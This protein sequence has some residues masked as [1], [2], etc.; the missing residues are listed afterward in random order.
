[1]AAPENIKPFLKWAGGKYRIIN[2]LRQNIPIKTRFFDVFMGSGA[3][4][5][6]VT[7]PS[8]VAN[9]ANGDVILPWRAMQSDA[10]KFVSDCE[11][12]FTPECDSPSVFYQL[13]QEFNQRT[14]TPDRRAALFVYLNRHSYNGLC[15]YNR[16]GEFNASFAHATPKTCPSDL[17][18]ACV[19]RIGACQFTNFDFREVMGSLMEG[20]VA[21]CDP[22]YWPLSRTAD[23]NRYHSE[24]FLRED[25]NDL[26]QCAVNAAKRGAIVVISNHLTSETAQLYAGASIQP[27]SVLRSISCGAR[28]SAQEAFFTYGGE[29]PLIQF[30]VIVDGSPVCALTVGC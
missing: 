2:Q 16:K 12:L 19:P 15:R 3:V 6:N 10:E 30:P 18:R 8:C 24:H 1:M 5:L 4:M 26:A 17:I 13:R 20:D 11:L 22:P 14:G 25:H 29:M 21:Y 7:S 27:L 23:F 28:G 9:D